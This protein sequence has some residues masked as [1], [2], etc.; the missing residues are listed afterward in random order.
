MADVTIRTCDHSKGIC[1]GHRALSH[2][3]PNLTPV[4]GPNPPSV[5]ATGVPTLEPDDTTATEGD[6]VAIALAAF[7]RLS[8]EH[9][10]GDALGLLE[11]AEGLTARAGLALSYIGEDDP[12]RTAV[13]HLFIEVTRVKNHLSG[14][15]ETLQ[16][17]GM[18]S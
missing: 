8:T 14:V 9:L 17:L 2:V 11:A 12:A 10:L 13:D 15:V 6:T 4:A 18:R 7:N 3:A 16:N 1:Y 5:P